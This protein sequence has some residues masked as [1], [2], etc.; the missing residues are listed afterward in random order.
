M[1]AVLAT[2]IEQ[3]RLKPMAT[4]NVFFT[5]SLEN[6]APLSV[7]LFISSDTAFQPPFDIRPHDEVINKRREYIAE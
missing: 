4:V 3:I 6:F 5:L 1:T 7:C 2:S